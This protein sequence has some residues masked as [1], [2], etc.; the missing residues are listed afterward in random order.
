MLEGPANDPEMEKVKK[1]ILACQEKSAPYDPS[2]KAGF[3]W[4]AEQFLEGLQVQTK[5]GASDAEGVNTIL[6][7][8]AVPAHGI[9][10]QGEVIYF[11]IPEA[12]GKAKSLD[13]EVHVYLF[14]HPPASPGDAL[15]Q[16]RTARK[17]LWCRSV[18]VEI[19]QGGKELAVSWHIPNRASP[20]L[21]RAPVPFRPAVTRGMQQVRVE[22]YNDVWDKYEYLF[23]GKPKWDPIY[24]EKETLTASADDAAILRGLELIPPQDREWHLVRGL[25]PASSGVAKSNKGESR[26][27]VALRESAP[28][29]GN[30]VLFSPR[31]RKVDL[32]AKPQ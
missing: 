27:E 24:D 32:M 3:A 26:F 21:L 18:G 14:D 12:L 11:E 7:I 28:E 23:E 19:K 1:H 6:I 15:A 2:L 8:G 17:T 31:R 9:P 20:Q 29:S 25:K 13:S 10:A 22:V 4:W 16:L 30:F 5:A